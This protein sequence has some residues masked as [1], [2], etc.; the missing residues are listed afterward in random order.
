[1]NINDFS[2]RLG[3]LIRSNQIQEAIKEMSRLL[4]DSPK[5]NELIV[6]S[7]RYNELK[8]QIR[9][10]TIDFENAQVAKNKILMALLDLSDEIIEYSKNDA[11]VAE[12]TDRAASKLMQSKIQVIQT[13]H[14]SGDNVGRDK[15]VNR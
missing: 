15:N 13:H 1:M 10:G 3:E 6:H 2:E 11:Q 12:E 8:E 5:L 9:L 7:A 14:G 4:K